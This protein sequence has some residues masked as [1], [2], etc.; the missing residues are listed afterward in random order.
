MKITET[1]RSCDELMMPNYLDCGTGE[2]FCQT[3]TI[4]K[5][6]EGNQDLAKI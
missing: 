3:R 1:G 2:A 6:S 4:G 5:G